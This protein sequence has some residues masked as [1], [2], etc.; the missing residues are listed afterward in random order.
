MIWLV[1]FLC[2]SVVIF[3]VSKV[4]FCGISIDFTCK[5]I[6]PVELSVIRYSLSV[7]VSV[8]TLNS[9][10]FVP[11]NSVVLRHSRAIVVRLV[12]FVFV[13]IILNSP[14]TLSFSVDQFSVNKGFDR[15]STSSFISM[16]TNKCSDWVLT[17]SAIKTLKRRVLCKGAKNNILLAT[18]NKFWG[19]YKVHYASRAEVVEKVF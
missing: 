15:L 11:S 6:S 5:F 12:R 19:K 7:V 14:L 3:I 16:P 4:T 10:W 13:L 17:V 8:W 1:K 9:G 18:F 2:V